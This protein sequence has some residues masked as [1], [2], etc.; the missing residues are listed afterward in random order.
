MA[1]GN[2]LT[3]KL[4]PLP[5]WV[6]LAGI[7]GLG[8]AWYLYEKNKQGSSSSGSPT[9]VGPALATTEPGTTTSTQFIPDYVFQNYNQLP[10]EQAPVV[11]VGPFTTTTP[12]SPPPP[13]SVPPPASA[14]AAEP[15]TV[16]SSP[17]SYTT[18]L[19]GPYDEWTSTG[20]YSLNTIA[21]SHGL[22]PQKLLADSLAAENNVPLQ[23]Y[24]KQN[25]FSKPVP[26]GVHLYIPKSNWAIRK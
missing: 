20:K 13:V 24:A 17:G 2:V 16:S 15:A 12:A 4:G 23:Q 9:A 6:W 5:T 22:T 25:N 26:A 19:P 3:E 11:N 18:G 7:T 1:D 10:A 14:P 8:L 21:K